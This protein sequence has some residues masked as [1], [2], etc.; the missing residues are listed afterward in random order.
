MGQC[1][2][3]ITT[4]FGRFKKRL[5]MAAKSSKMA[6]MRGAEAKKSETTIAVSSAKARRISRGNSVEIRR[7]RTSATTAKMRGETGHP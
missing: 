2:R 6:L 3:G 4:V 5:E 7:R 1:Q